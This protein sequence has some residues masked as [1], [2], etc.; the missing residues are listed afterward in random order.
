MSGRS[1]HK[2][3]LVGLA[4]ALGGVTCEPGLVRVTN[5][6]P[7]APLF[8]EHGQVERDGLAALIASV[9]EQRGL[10]FTQRPDLEVLQPTD[11]RVPALAAAAQALAPCP[12]SAEGADVAAPGAGACFPDPGLQWVLCLP[13]ADPAEIRRALGRVLDG[14]SY[15]RLVRTA[16]RLQGDPGVALRSLLA[17]SVAREAM[18]GIGP[19]PGSE[20]YELLDEAGVEVA[21]QSGAES[22]CTA[23]ATSFLAAQ[24]DPEGPFRNPPLST[25]QLV[26]P[27]AY[28]AG[29]RPRELLGSAPQPEDC[30][31]ASDESIGVARLL[32]EGMA[33]GGTLPTRELAA[34][35]GDRGIRLECADERKAWIYVAELRSES[36]TAPF[37]ARVA[38]LLPAGFEGDA[39]TVI[40]SRRVAVFAGLQP[41]EA[42][43][44]AASLVARERTRFDAPTGSE[45]R[46]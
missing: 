19:L 8:D 29:E 34:W 13:P 24:D 28:R 42:R 14:Q 4:L 30:T 2:L 16:P 10:R 7:D 46:N 23:A 12:R 45:E 41:G 26:S 15:P 43:A 11:P 25:K 3:A 5:R 35:L 9:E 33:K 44:F 1:D 20:A 36:T 27:R 32:V 37:A 17:A 38:S 40:V 39:G 6:P 31:V 21:A 22:F 18:V